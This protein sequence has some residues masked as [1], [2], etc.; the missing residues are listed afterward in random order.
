MSGLRLW[1]RVRFWDISKAFDRVWHA[2][3]VHK[4]QVAGISG[5]LLHWFINHLSDRKQRVVL[6]G[7]QFKWNFIYAGVPQ[8]SIIGPLLIL[9]YIND[10]VVDIRSSIRLFAD[11]TS[12]DVIV[13]NPNYSAQLL[14]ADLGKIT[15]WAETC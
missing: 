5:N 11:D 13:E 12:L 6:P 3:L 15:R 7:I 2:G 9:L 8:V 1:K 10:I 4:L 14:N